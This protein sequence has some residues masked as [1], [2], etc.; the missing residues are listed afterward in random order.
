MQ[1]GSAYVY[2]T[3]QDTSWKLSNLSINDTQS[4]P[5]LTIDVLYKKYAKTSWFKKLFQQE[6]QIGYVLYNDQADT[7]TVKKGHTKGILLFDSTSVVWIVHSIPHYPP[8]ISSGRYYINSSQLVFGQSMLCMRTKF[9]ALDSIGKQLLFNNPQVY[10]YSIPNYFNKKTTQSSILSNL[11]SVINGGHVKAPPWFNTVSFQT[12]NNRHEFL[13]FAKYGSFAQDLYTGLVAQ[14]LQSNLYTETWNNGRG[15]LSSNCTLDFHVLNIENVS[16]ESLNVSF[17]VHKDHSKWAVTMSKNKTVVCIGD[18]NRQEDQ[19][20][21][22]GGTLCLM[23]EKNIWSSYR[24]L[25][26]DTQ[27]C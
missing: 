26:K 21:R 2:M 23:N 9:E 11:I 15:T 13:S 14:N 24:N 17:S 3:E 27:N 20:K 22:G 7:V 5:A 16:F 12:F 1:S 25:V 6:N 19:F 4:M 18:I 10:D 8:K